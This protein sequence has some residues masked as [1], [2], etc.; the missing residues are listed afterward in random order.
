[1][2][3][4]TACTAKDKVIMHGHNVFVTKKFSLLRLNPLIIAAERWLKKKLTPSVA[5]TVT[6]EL[7]G[8]LKSRS[9]IY[10][11]IYSHVVIIRLTATPIDLYYTT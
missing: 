4:F 3:F 7:H 10:K 5:L 1:M 11:Y 9:S 2:L 6:L 8:A